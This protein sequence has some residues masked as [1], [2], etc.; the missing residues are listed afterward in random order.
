MQ[1]LTDG[2]LCTTRGRK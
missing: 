2:Q 1:K